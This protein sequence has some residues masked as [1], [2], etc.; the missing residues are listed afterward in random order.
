MD[1]V[2]LATF[3]AGYVLDT[4]YE[5]VAVHRRLGGA[6]SCCEEDV[7]VAVACLD[8]PSSSAD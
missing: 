4:G 2:V 6:L 8:A 7:T 3:S 1:T 5:E